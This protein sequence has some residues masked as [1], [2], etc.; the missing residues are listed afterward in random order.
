M[1]LFRDKHFSGGKQRQSGSTFRDWVVAYVWVGFLLFSEQIR[2]LYFKWYHP[3]NREL[4]GISSAQLI[5]KHLA[6]HNYLGTDLPN[7]LESMR[8]PRPYLNLKYRRQRHTI[9]YYHRENSTWQH[10]SVTELTSLPTFPQATHP[11]SHKPQPSVFPAQGLL[12]CFEDIY[13]SIK[14]DN[15]FF[16]LNQDCV[17]LFSFAWGIDGKH[18]SHSLHKQEFQRQLTLSWGQT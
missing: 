10:T 15:F 7:T 4:L 16:L 8:Q 11:S 13:C 14:S 6:S 2:R 3:C 18:T 12:P 1:L 17:V 9:G 5:S